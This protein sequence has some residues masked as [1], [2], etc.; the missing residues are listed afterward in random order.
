MTS[1]SAVN[2]PIGRRRDDEQRQ[3]GHV[4]SN[5]RGSLNQEGVAEVTFAEMV[6]TKNRNFASPEAL[7][8]RALTAA[9][10]VLPVIRFRPLQQTADVTF[11][12]ILFL[13]IYLFRNSIVKYKSRTK[14]V[15]RRKLKRTPKVK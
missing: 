13:F 11:I 3:K 8:V 14:H 12:F 9:R 10:D 4:T 1:E 7:R 5:G 6:E 15:K 2:D